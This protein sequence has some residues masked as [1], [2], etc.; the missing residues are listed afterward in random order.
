MAAGLQNGTFL[1]QFVSLIGTW[2]TRKTDTAASKGLIYHAQLGGQRTWAQVF[3]SLND[4][5]DKS[6]FDDISAQHATELF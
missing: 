6:E 1:S 2:N 3:L 5:F 4:T